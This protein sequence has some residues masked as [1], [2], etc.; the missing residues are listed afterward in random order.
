MNPTVK[1]LAI[2]G[3]GKWGKNLIREF[4]KNSTIIMCCSTGNKK[5]IRWLKRNFPNIQH[6]KNFQDILDNKSV[7]V[8]VIATPIKTHFS[9]SYQAIKSKKHLFIEKTISENLDDAK[10]LVRLA[11][12]E[13][14]VLFAGYIFLYHPI[15]EKIKKII[16]NEPILF[17]KL[18]WM[19]LGS[20]QE[21]ILLDLLSHFISIMIEL[22]GMPKSMKIINTRK[23]ITSNDI[24]TIEFKFNKYCKCLVDINRISNFKKQSITIL[25]SKNIFQWEDN[26]LFKF[27]K[28]KLFYK[29]MLI[30]KI[31]PLES[32]CKAFINNLDNKYD[33]S[34]IDKALKI[35]QLT[36]KCVKMIK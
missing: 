30:P 25:T 27:D 5:N 16:K 19:K 4:S 10:K 13:R 33:F 6:T 22:L 17:L 3:I 12:E 18:T 35:I 32:E 31:S 1:N 23:I 7:N 8:V 9:L 2:I 36:E 29:Q 20:F 24:I 15:L 11:K 34:N 26:T 28:R 14:I 21:N